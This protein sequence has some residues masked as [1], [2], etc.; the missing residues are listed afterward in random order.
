MNYYIYIDD[1]R[2]D[3]RWFNTHLDGEIWT[4]FIA[5]SYEDAI[6]FLIQIRDS[7]AEAIL[8]LDHD[9]G[10]LEEMSGEPFNGLSGYDICKYIVEHHYP[11][12]GFHIHSMNP[13]G[14]QNMRQILTHAGYEELF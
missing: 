14:A 7:E 10:E 6:D 4:P 8:D 1:I 5:R 12:V 11:L 2:E 13:V 3:S 9:L